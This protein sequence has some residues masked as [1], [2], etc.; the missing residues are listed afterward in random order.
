LTVQDNVLNMGQGAIAEAAQIAFQQILENIND[1]NTSALAKRKMTLELTFAP[2]DDRRREFRISV[3][4]T[5]KLAPNVPTVTT[6]F[7]G[8]RGGKLAAEEAHQPGLFD[9]EEEPAQEAEST[10]TKAKGRALKAV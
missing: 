7:V 6:I 10:T 1:P 2:V 3:V 5:S 4:A 9:E 8:R